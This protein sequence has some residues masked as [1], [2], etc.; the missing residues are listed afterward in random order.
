MRVS[1]GPAKKARQQ[2]WVHHDLESIKILWPSARVESRS[3]Q[4]VIYPENEDDAHGI[5]Q[6]CKG[7]VMWGVAFNGIDRNTMYALEN[8][9]ESFIKAKK[10]DNPELSYSLE[11][12]SAY[13]TITQAMIAYVSD[14]KLAMLLKLSIRA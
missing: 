6:L 11:R 5:A 10:K 13:G 3:D 7:T 8:E 9:V 1:I 4:V 2:Q 14:P 12:R